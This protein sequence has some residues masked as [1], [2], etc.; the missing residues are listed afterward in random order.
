MRIDNH[1]LDPD[2]TADP[3]EFRFSRRVEAILVKTPMMTYAEVV[4]AYQALEAEFIQDAGYNEW[5]ALETKRRIAEAMLQS[6]HML[7]Q[8]FETCRDNWNA[9]VE[10]GFSSIQTLCNMA[11]LYVDSCLF[12]AH[13]DAG[14]EVIDTVFAEI[15]RR[16]EEPSITREAEEY[17]DQEI[18]SFGKLHD[19]LV[20]HLSSEA[21]GI[22]WDE[23]RETAADSHEEP[24][25]EQ[26][27]QIE[28]M[29]RLSKVISQVRRSSSER[30][31]SE[32]VDAYRQA[33]A[34]FIAQFQPTESFYQVEVRRQILY[35]ILEES[36]K[37]RQPFEVGC[38]VWDEV[39]QCGF[40][41]LTDR[42]AI[43][44]L[45]AGY[46]L[47]NQQRNAGIA[48]IEPLLAELRTHI[49]EGTNTEMPVQRY[50][51]EIA[52]LEKLRDELRAL[53]MSDI[54]KTT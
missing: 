8:P 21:E 50:P 41:K 9:L 34:D 54:G 25:P 32:N 37:R 27:L 10:L 24:S 14:L 12:H 46:C 43:T 35:G 30:S 40:A 33:E 26:R 16:L 3:R 36:Y 53:P 2:R 19:G 44:R 48:V 28:L 42:C 1:L 18:T 52:R 31:F 51:R 5:E 38:N 45:Y 15:H 11:W 13:Y 23:R 29:I 20:A 22:A 17:Y 47:F 4:H 49:D 7:E 39:V 6:A